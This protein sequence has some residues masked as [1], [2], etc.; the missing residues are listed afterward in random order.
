[1]PSLGFIGKATANQ[2]ETG[3]LDLLGQ[4][5]AYDKT[6]LIVRNQGACNQAI[7][8]GYKT[9]R[10]TPTIASPLDVPATGLL[11]YADTTLLAQL[12]TAAPTWRDRDP[13]IILTGDGDTANLELYEYVNAALAAITRQT[14]EHAA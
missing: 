11:I 6:G 4:A 2:D 12:D 14:L 10:G 3:L 1:M 13:T 8:H 9:M 7:L 5:L